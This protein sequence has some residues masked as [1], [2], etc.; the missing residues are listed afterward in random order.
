MC[1]GPGLPSASRQTSPPECSGNLGVPFGSLQ[2][3]CKAACNAHRF[4]SQ[5][6]SNPT[7]TEISDNRTR[8]VWALP[9]VPCQQGRGSGGGMIQPW[10]PG[11]PRLHLLQ[12]DSPGMR[13]GK[14]TAVSSAE[15]STGL[16]KS[17]QKSMGGS[18]M[19]RQRQMQHG[20]SASRVA[21]PGGL[22]IDGD[23]MS[24]QRS[25]GEL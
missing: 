6:V 9:L 5:K 4:G 10:P 7:Q 20:S 15:S 22:S 16:G 19:R 8:T 12:G 3:P 24:G 18:G 2:A 21:S 23:P 25:E 13:R 14:E 11:H 17:A 1:G